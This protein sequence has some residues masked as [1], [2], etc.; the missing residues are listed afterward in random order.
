MNRNKQGN[1]KKQRGHGRFFLACTAFAA[2]LITCI[3]AVYQ[4]IVPKFLYDNDWPTTSGY[5]G[6]YQ[7]EAHTADVLF[8]GSSHAASFFIPQELYNSYGITSYNLGCE[9]QNLVVSYYWLKEALRYQQPKAV[10]LDCYMLF[11]Y[12]A[13][14][15]LNTAESCTRK[16]LDFM[17]WSPVKQEAVKTIC[18]LDENQSLLSYYFPNIRYHTRWKGLSQNDF[19]AARQKS[20]YELKGYAPLAGYCGYTE[21]A[22]FE[23]PGSE[24]K[25]AMVPL[26]E[27]YLDK[28]RLLCEQNSI[29]LI[30]VKNPSTSQTAEKS[31]AIKDYADRHN[32]LFL[33][34]NEKTLYDQAGYCF[35]A[36]NHD[37]GHGNLWGAQK[38]TN[39]LGRTLKEQGIADSKTSQQWEQTK[40]YYKGIQKD[41]CLAH[42][43]DLDTYLYQLKDSRYDIF[44][45]SKGDCT[46]F[47]KESSAQMLARL[48]CSTNLYGAQV[49]GFLAVISDG[50]AAEQAGAGELAA[51][52]TLAD[53]FITYDIR[54]ADTEHAEASSIEIDGTQ[55]S[56]NSR[57]LNIVV[58]R[59]DIKKVVDAV[60]FDTG[61]EGNPAI[62]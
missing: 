30:L 38:I 59:R 55:R 52:G 62:R 42:I 7:L 10:I 5:R 43:S 21:F 14:E 48:S 17:K 50:S 60:C 33:D 2:L 51:E 57:G 23:R 32:L 24:T 8:F 26:M 35:A 29:S 41:C 19:H 3:L 6:F 18:A 28:L 34:Y 46:S 56:K 37:G 49:P 31:A 39:D 27:A 11:E 22:P 53:S 15:P 36:D 12:N 20:H 4:I 45:A 13:K 54:S 61:A 1:P 16:A 9:Q 40:A 25:A 47:F 44:I 58:Y